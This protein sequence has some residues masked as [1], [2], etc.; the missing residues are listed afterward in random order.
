MKGNKQHRKTPPLKTES[1]TAISREEKAEAFA[2]ALQT[3]FKPNVSI[4]EYTQLHE[5]IE[6]EKY[7]TINPNDDAILPTTEGEVRS[8][9]SNL[10]NK[11]APG[12]DKITNIA[13]KKLPDQAVTAM[14]DII[15]AVLKFHYYP[16]PWKQA[17]IIMIAKPNKPRNTPKGYRPISL[18]SAISKVTE[19]IILTKLE[20]EIEEK[21]IIPNFQF[22]FRKE[23]GTT[24]Q[25]ARLT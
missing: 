4:P 16:E 14:T 5:A 17:E 23:H 11:K 21:K 25:L 22:G 19:R 24:Q 20:Q 1:G 15:N 12:H 10:K 8:T 13:L 18:L 2:D 6:R 9:I 3:A 7:T